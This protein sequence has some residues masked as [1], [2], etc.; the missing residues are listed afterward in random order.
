MCDVRPFCAGLCTKTAAYLMSMEASQA[1]SV[2]S[3]TL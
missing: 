1:L 3:L 2:T